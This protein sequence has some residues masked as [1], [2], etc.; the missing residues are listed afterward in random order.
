VSGGRTFV[1][2]AYPPNALGYCGPVDANDLGIADDRAIDTYARAFGGAWPYL[3]LIAQANGIDD[4]LDDR[5]VR[6]YW[7][8]NDLLDAVD[9][10]LLRSSLERRFRGG[11]GRDWTRMSSCIESAHRA[12]HGLHV[13]RMYPWAGLLRTGAAGRAVDV[14]DRCRIRAGR[15]LAV[16][17]G[18][19]TVQSTLLA[20]DGDT[21]SLGAPQA[22]TVALSIGT[23]LEPG[24]LVACHWGWACDRLTDEQLTVL[25]SDTLAELAV[26][27]EWLA[28]AGSVDSSPAM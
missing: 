10:A 26:V 17:G 24:D 23:E 19:V 15:V 16:D 8:G 9:P 14:L 12:H 6:A 7:I 3:E 27:N 13:F 21:L 2:Y 1:R 28:V 5:V 25:E 22:E 20:W 11:A 18:T 4:P